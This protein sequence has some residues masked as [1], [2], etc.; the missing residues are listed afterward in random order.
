VGHEIA[1]ERQIERRQGEGLVVD[2]LRRGSA[3]AEQ[4]DRPEGRIVGNA[5]DQFARFRAM[6]HGLND[7]A[8]YMRASGFSER[9]R[10]IISA[11]VLRTASA[12]GQAEFHAADIGFM[13][14]VARPDFDGDRAVLLKKRRRD[15]GGLV[16]IAAERVG[17]TGMP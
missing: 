3:M 6:N 7:H 15:F 16:R 4:N 12:C 11:V 5:H 1:R 2:H 14:D 8:G 13:H 9:T 17:T 10:A